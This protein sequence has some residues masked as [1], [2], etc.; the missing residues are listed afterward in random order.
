MNSKLM[1]LSACIATFAGT[2]GQAEGD[3]ALR[4]QL[5]NVAPGTGQLLI[6]VCLEKD[7][8]TPDCTVRLAVP[9]TTNPQH[10]NVPRPALPPGRYA[11]QVIYDRNTNNKL[12]TNLLRIPQEPVGFSRDAQGRMGPPK[13]EQAAFE[14]DGSALT[15]SIH[16][17]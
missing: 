12:D 8:L 14:F 9:A 17:Y 4:L 3:P 13:F 10:V 11:V 16:L 7:F 6:A 2:L 15:L 5:Y 1:G